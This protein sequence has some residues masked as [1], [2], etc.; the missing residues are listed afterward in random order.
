MFRVGGSGMD[1][2]SKARVTHFFT[3]SHQKKTKRE[4]TFI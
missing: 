1:M 2:R 4:K 3:L